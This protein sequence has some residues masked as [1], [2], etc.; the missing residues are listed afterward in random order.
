MVPRTKV[1]LVHSI[2]PV[3]SF[4]CSRILRYYLKPFTL[5]QVVPLGKVIKAKRDYYNYGA[6]SPT[7]FQNVGVSAFGWVSIIAKIIEY[8]KVHPAATPILLYKILNIC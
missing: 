1:Y 5:G 7:L 4:E 8:N 2:N 3:K 6:S